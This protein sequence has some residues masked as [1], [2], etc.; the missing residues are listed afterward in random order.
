MKRP[1]I[2]KIG[3]SQHPWVC[4]WNHGYGFKCSFS[5]FEDALGYAFEI[6]GLML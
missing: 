2:A 4:W 3:D 5:R 6:Q 1:R